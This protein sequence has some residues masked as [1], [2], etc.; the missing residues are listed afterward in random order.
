MHKQ[1]GM[2]GGDPSIDQQEIEIDRNKTK[3]EGRGVILT[4]RPTAC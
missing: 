2:K 4:D 3:R 1:R